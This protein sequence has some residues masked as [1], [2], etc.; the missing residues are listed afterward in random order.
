MVLSLTRA[1][2][3]AVLR[4]VHLRHAGDVV[5]AVV[6]VPVGAPVHQVTALDRLLVLVSVYPRRLIFNASEILSFYKE[7]RIEDALSRG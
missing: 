3:P 1:D 7:S 4:T 6:E 2:V 5:V